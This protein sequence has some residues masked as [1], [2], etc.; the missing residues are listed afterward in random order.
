MTR[1][2]LYFHLFFF[3]SWFDTSRRTQLE[4]NKF[5]LSSASFD[6]CY[7]D[8]KSSQPISINS[9]NDNSIRK[10]TISSCGNQTEKR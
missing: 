7:F 9:I 10:G 2:S 4:V 3:S 8:L 5:L 1:R 6:K